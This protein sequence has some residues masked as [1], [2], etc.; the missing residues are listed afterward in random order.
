MRDLVQR[1]ADLPDYQV[2]LFRLYIWGLSPNRSLLVDHFR[3][4]LYQ[5][6]TDHSFQNELYEKM[7][8]QKILWKS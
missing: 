2:H 5:G 3:Y 1:Q 7:Y 4:K 6:F 8:Q